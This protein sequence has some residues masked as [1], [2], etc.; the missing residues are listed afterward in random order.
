MWP[1]LGPD[2]NLFVLVGAEEREKRI[3]IIELGHGACVWS[4]TMVSP[5]AQVPVYPMVVWSPVCPDTSAGEES[6]C[7]RV[8]LYGPKPV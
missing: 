4:Q 7:W 5:T 1:G 8:E 3:I 2:G 6:H